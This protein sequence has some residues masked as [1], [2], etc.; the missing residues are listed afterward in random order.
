MPR[1]RE[2]RVVVNDKALNREDDEEHGE[3]EEEETEKTGFIIVAVGG[4]EDLD[5]LAAIFFEAE[6]NET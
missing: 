2:Y 6:E 5:E 4:V 3:T 1:H